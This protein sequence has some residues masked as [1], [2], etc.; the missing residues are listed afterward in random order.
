MQERIRRLGA[1]KASRTVASITLIVMMTWCI[2][3]CFAWIAIYSSY[4]GEP[5]EATLVARA[6]VWTWVFLCCA[7]L[8]GAAAT[9]L[10]ASLVDMLS[11]D[12]LPIPRY[13]VSALVVLSG[14][15]VV[16]LILILFRQH[17]HHSLR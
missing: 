16:V 4:F 9:R 2:L 8:I 1:A 12:L 10:V 11:S 3:K 17:P 6:H 13:V 14:S 5:G 15:V 7:A